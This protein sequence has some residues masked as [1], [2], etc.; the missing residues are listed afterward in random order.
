MSS[1][2]Y[3]PSNAGVPGLDPNLPTPPLRRHALGLP[4]GSV[5]AILAVMVVGMTCILMLLSPLHG[6]VI[7]IPPYLWYLLFLTLGHFFAIH[8]HG[9]SPTGLAEP[10]PLYLPRGFVRLFILGIL[11]ATVAWKL[12]H[13]MEGFQNQLKESLAELPKQPFLPLVLLGGFILGV[14]IHFVVGRDY[15]PYWF[16]DF[17][18]WVALLAVFGLS[19]DAIIHLVI[20][21]TLD[22]PLNAYGLQ[23]FIAAV[24]AFYFGARS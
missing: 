16:E 21:P 2:P 1:T 9:H 20:N 5:R 11:V 12:T 22:D 13:D 6:R 24:I 3:P 4:R 15:T 23:M 7:P 19:I 18:A 10:S 8:G 17:E 14:V